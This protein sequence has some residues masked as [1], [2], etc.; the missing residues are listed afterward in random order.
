MRCRSTLSPNP[1]RILLGMRKPTG[2]R[3]GIPPMSSGLGDVPRSLDAISSH[4]AGLRI[5][6]VGIERPSA[7]GPLIGSAVTLDRRQPVAGLRLGAGFGRRPGEGAE[8][9]ASRLAALVLVERIEGHALRIRQDTA[10]GRARNMDGA[11]G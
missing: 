1:R 3:G 8:P 10:T 6:R 11:G 7:I 2:E 5:L 4:V 9:G